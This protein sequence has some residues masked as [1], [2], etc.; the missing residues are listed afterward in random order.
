[1]GRFYDM[2]WETKLIDVLLIIE[3]VSNDVLGFEKKLLTECESTI[4]IIKPKQ[5]IK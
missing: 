5:S 4:E 3:I 2:K 1:M